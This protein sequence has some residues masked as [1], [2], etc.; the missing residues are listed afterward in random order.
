LMGLYMALFISSAVYAG[1]LFGAM[2]AKWTQKEILVNWR[3]AAIGIVLLHFTL[4]VPFI[5][6]AV[7]M[8][9]MFTA[10]GAL[11]GALYDGVWLSRKEQSELVTVQNITEEN[12]SEKE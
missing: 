7:V 1:I 5:G 3:W 8:V 10:F 11:L 12:N 9:F 4:L 6:L 2:L